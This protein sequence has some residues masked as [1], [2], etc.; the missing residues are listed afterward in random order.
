MAQVR[1]IGKL[2]NSFYSKKKNYAEIE[3]SVNQVV[4]QISELD[5]E[6]FASRI[7]NNRG[8]SNEKR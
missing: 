2:R 6:E 8:G 4:K 7:K 5:I 1:L 3:I